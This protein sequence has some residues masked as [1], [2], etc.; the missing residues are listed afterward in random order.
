MSNSQPNDQSNA[1]DLLALF[2]RGTE[3]VNQLLEEKERLLQQIT[4]LEKRQGCTTP[5]SIKGDEP[6]E[7]GTR[8]AEEEMRATL[9]RLREL[10]EENQQFAQRY[11]EIQEENSRLVNLYVASS[12]LHSTLELS[13]VLETIVEIVINLVGAEKIAIYE[14]NEGTRSIEAVAVE[15]VE[16]DELPKFQLGSGVVGRSV[17]SGDIEYHTDQEPED[18][19]Q[20]IVCVPLRMKGQPIGAITIY[21][22]LDQKAAFDAKD[23]ELFT[24]LGEHAATALFAAR[25]FAES[26]RR[27]QMFK[28]FCELLTK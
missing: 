22:L 25:L 27:L 20:P 18:P 13:E 11:I 1:E 17:D 3:T 9:E 10:E 12:Q 5:D 15:G 23:H 19:N 28:G 6:A 16:I 8:R 14:L 2:S 21:G 4:D 7:V 24:L 26:K